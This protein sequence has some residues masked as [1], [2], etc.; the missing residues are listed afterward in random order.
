MTAE[1]ERTPARPAVTGTQLMPV[2]AATV[3]AGDC[4]AGKP[5]GGG[6]GGSLDSDSDDR[7]SRAGFP[8]PA[9]SECR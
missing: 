9:A 6:D 3:T 5:E 7:G 4:R 1:S 2:P 8:G